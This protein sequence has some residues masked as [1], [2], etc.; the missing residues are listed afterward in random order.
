MGTFI[1][2]CHTSKICICGIV[3]KDR[4]YGDQGGSGWEWGAWDWSASVGRS[5][6]IVVI[7]D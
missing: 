4:S 7:Y 3:G 1:L 5:F 2:S 6:A